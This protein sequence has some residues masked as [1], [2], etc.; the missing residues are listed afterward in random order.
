M[1]SDGFNVNPSHPSSDVEKLC[2]KVVFFIKTVSLS[3]LYHISISSFI[4][5]RTW[6]CR[7]GIYEFQKWLKFWKIILK[8]NVK[9]ILECCPATFLN[10]HSSVSIYFSLPHLEAQLHSCSWKQA[11]PH[12]KLN[13]LNIHFLPY[14][15]KLNMFPGP[16]IWA[17]IL[18]LC[19]CS[20]LVPITSLP[21]FCL[22]SS[23]CLNLLTR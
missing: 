1:A 17:L 5:E 12:W 11:S 21:S 8:R 9:W 20:H 23:P 16:V 3:S 15:F 18:F 19:S 10:P 22:N 6:G 13:E 2:L 14:R 7:K 4:T